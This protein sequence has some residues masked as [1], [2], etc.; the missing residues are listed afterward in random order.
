M[1]KEAGGK[2]PSVQRQPVLMFC[3]IM[4]IEVM[5]GMPFYVSFVIYKHEHFSMLLKYL[6]FLPSYRSC[7]MRQDHLKIPIPKDNQCQ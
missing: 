3:H 7:Y 2:C 6:T 5:Q 1:F 4:Y